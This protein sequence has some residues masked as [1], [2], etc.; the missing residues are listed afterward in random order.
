MKQSRHIQVEYDVVLQK[1][2]KYIEV[3][4]LNFCRIVNECLFIKYML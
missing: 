1:R 4:Q 2:F 3:F